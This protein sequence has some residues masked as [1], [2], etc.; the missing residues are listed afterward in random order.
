MGKWDKRDIGHLKYLLERNRESSIH[1]LAKIA[2]KKIKNRSTTAITHKLRELQAEQE[3][4]EREIELLGSVFPAKFV[5][6]YIFIEI[7]HSR[8]MPAHIWVWETA[9]NLKT[10]KGYHV[11]HR[12]GN[13]LNNRSTNLDLMTAN[14]HIALHRGNKLPESAFLFYFL[15]ERELWEEYMQYRDKFI[16]DYPLPNGNSG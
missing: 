2:Q 8:W 11:H 10:P 13:R 6:G 1:A 3:F 16:K 5:S 9:N 12:D 15:F 7:E 4:T 14:D